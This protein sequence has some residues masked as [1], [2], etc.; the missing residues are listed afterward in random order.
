MGS[1]SSRGVEA[2]GDRAI[3]PRGSLGDHQPLRR[4]GLLPEAAD[5]LIV[6]GCEVSRIPRS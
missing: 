3:G 5:G 6:V 1:G 4:S 2:G